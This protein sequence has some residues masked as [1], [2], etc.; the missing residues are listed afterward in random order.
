MLHRALAFVSFIFVFVST[1][2][3]ATSSSRHLRLSQRCDSAFRFLEKEGY[4]TT[5]YGALAC[6]ILTGD[7]KVEFRIANKTLVKEPSLDYCK[8]YEHLMGA[9]SKRLR[10]G[11]SGTV[12]FHCSDESTFPSHVEKHLLFD[13]GS[14]FATHSHRRAQD[15]NCPDNVVWV[16]DPHFINDAG[17][18][19][20]IFKI[21]K[22]SSAG[23]PKRKVVFWR[24]STTGGGANC[25]DLLRIKFAMASYE[26]EHMDVKVS[27]AVQLCADEDSKTMLKAAGLIGDHVDERLW[28]ENWGVADVTGN[29]HAFGIFWRLASGSVVFRVEDP[30]NRFCSS[31]EQH[32]KPWIHYVPVRPNDLQ[33]LH[34]LTK[35]LLD[36]EATLTRIRDAAYELTQRHDLE[37]E[38][39][40]VA[41]SLEESWLLHRSPDSVQNSD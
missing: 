9:V 15:G 25:S 19:K 12:I 21:R 4:R 31:L 13:L 20:K 34:N 32:L 28:A 11:S 22:R 38:V 35:S 27:S 24:G 26:V 41:E 39:R 18:K 33:T 1:S 8:Q 30:A 16:P 3:S 23:L 10:R 17:F 40:R 5:T 6:A 29:V 2:R 14:P 37:S 36:D 7:D